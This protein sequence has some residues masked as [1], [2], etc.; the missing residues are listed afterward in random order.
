MDAGFRWGGAMAVPAPA[1]RREGA[2]QR[3]TRLLDEIGF[4]PELRESG[5]DLQIRLNHRPFLDLTA[6][7]SRIVCLI[8]LGLMR[9]ME[10]LDPTVSVRDLQPFAEPDRCVAQLEQTGLRSG[11]H[12]RLE[13]GDPVRRATHHSGPAR[14]LTDGNRA[15]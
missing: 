9:A 1:P 3:L 7:G 10:Q 4:E 13:S 14:L 5:K 2:A 12:A 15:V 8:H 11:H 6:T